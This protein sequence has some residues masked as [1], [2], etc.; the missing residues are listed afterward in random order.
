MEYRKL[1]KTGV[2][3]SPVCLGTMMFGLRT[4][5]SDSIRIIQKAIDHG[6]N[7]I[8]T[9]DMYAKGESERIL[10]KAI[11]DRRDQVVLA[12]KGRQK[13][14]DGPNDE[15]GSR[16]HL[17]KALDA[18]LKRL[19]LDH[20]DLYYYHAPH[21]TPIEETLQALAELVAEGKPQSQW[22]G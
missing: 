9:A 17:M 18:S 21:D 16:L 7:F 11:A 8:D 4:E 15:G 12:T 5:E 13:M 10:G 2:K 19:N 22:S 1:G 14:G 3:V 6:I 20:V